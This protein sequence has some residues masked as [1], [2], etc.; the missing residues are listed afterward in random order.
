MEVLVEIWVFTFLSLI[1]L[2]Y[3]GKIL[4]L[5]GQNSRL[6]SV[7]FPEDKDVANPQVDIEV[8]GEKLHTILHLVFSESIWMRRSAS[9]G[10]C[11]FWNGR[12]REPYQFCER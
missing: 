1:C 8:N 4:D 5:L 2:K 3:I 6:K 10:T 11:Q 7:F 9:R 12:Q